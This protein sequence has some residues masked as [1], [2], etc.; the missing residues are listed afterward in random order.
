MVAACVVPRLTDP[1]SRLRNGVRDRVGVQRLQEWAV[2]VLDNPPPVG[3]GLERWVKPEQMPENIRALLPDG[4]V[5][6]YQGGRPGVGSGEHVLFACGG[7][8]FHYGLRVGRSG[9]QPEPDSQFHYEELADG[10]WGLYER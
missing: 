7:G 4:A 2:S 9:F 10:V 6:C 3:P 8:F 1:Y 5:V